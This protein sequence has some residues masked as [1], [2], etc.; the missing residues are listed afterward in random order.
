MGYYL[1]D[2]A[3]TW[4]RLSE[5]KLTGWEKTK[6]LLKTRF[7]GINKEEVKRKLFTLEF[8]GSIQKFNE[9]FEGYANE[10]EMNEKDLIELFKS[11]M[12]GSTQIELILKKGTKI[13]RRSDGSGRVV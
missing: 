9:Q 1:Q 4:Y 13:S 6:N 7:G 8:T 2:K 3:L 11:K 12:R 10:L 5:K